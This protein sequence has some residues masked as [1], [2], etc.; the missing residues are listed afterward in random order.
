MLLGWRPQEFWSATPAELAACLASPNGGAE[1]AGKD[2]LAD[3]LRR[4]PD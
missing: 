1:G 3:L 2:V 4:F